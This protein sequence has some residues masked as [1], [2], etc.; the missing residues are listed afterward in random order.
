MPSDV[1]TE[2][3]WITL[4]VLRT[5][6][7]DDAAVLIPILAENPTRSGEEEVV[8]HLMAMQK[9]AYCN[10]HSTTGQL[11]VRCEPLPVEKIGV[12]QFRSEMRAVHGGILGTASVDELSKR[13]SPRAGRWPISRSIRRR[14]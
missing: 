13:S 7:G 10:A 4:F 5:L 6:L 1:E 2:A 12:L 9:P 8:S 14:I 3:A 11:V